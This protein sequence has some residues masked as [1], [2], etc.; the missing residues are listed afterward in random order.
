MR[1][2]ECGEGGGGDGAGGD[3]R[4][5]GVKYSRQVPGSTQRVA[6]KRSSANDISR[7]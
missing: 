2:A 4:W 7:P 6:I 1:S 3:G 5:D